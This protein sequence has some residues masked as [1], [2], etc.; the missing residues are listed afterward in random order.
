MPCR[1]MA[2]T[3]LDL[4][5]YNGFYNFLSPPPRKE[6]A[7]FALVGRAVDQAMSG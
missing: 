5:W 6:G 4:Y 7:F 3:D 1:L 2:C